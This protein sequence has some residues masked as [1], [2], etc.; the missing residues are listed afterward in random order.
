MDNFS[1]LYNQTFANL[2]Q[3]LTVMNAI[4]SLFFAGAVARDAGRLARLGQPTILVNG[5]T[6]SFATLCGGVYIGAL[7]WLLH[8]SS[9]TRP[10]SDDRR[11][12]TEDRL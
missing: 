2:P 1:N 10:R 12:V 6:W 9:L 7:Y 8:H 5:V 11:V 3:F 4:I